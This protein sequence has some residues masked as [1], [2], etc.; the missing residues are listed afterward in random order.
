MPGA[1]LPAFVNS[2]TTSC[3]H[4]IA[5]IAQ[6]KRLPLVWD[7]LSAPH[8]TWKALLPQTVAVGAAPD[9]GWILKPAFGRVGQGINIP[10]TVS[11]KENL[12]I[13]RAAHANKGQ[14]VQQRMFQS[15]PIA[16]LHLAIGVFAINGVFAGCFARASR[17]PLMDFNAME[18]PVLRKSK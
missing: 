11:A 13:K 8:K 7:Q 14:W 3:N 5:V 1:D 9:K 16:G 10:G 15:L 17:T 18:L 6:S 2:A 12:E 4:P